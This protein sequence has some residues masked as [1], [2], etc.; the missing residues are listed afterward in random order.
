MTRLAAALE[1]R[2]AGMTLAP[3]GLQATLDDGLSMLIARRIVT[4]DLRPVP[5][6]QGLLQFYAASVQQ[7]LGG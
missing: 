3:Q 1:A 6:Q 4:A 7:R 2:G 5:A